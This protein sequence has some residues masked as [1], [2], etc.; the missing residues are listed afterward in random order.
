MVRNL[1]DNVLV[2]LETL[3]S[4]RGR[5]LEG[6]ARMALELWTEPLRIKREQSKRREE[7]AA[8]LNELL[9]GINET[10]SSRFLRP[11]HVAEAIGETH[12]E[13]VECWF[14]GEA[15]PSLSQLESVADYLGGTRDWL[16]HG[17]GSPFLV[18][19][20]R[21]P[22]NPTEAVW[23]LLQASGAGQKLS[24]LHLVRAA[25]AEGQLAIVKQYEDWR[26]E[27][28]ITPLHISEENGGTGQ[29]TLASF[30]V[31]LCLLYNTNLKAGCTVSSYVVGW[32]KYLSLINGQVHPLRLFTPQSKS[33]W[34]EDVW[35]ESLFRKH[36]RDV[37]WPGWKSLCEYISF[38]IEQSPYLRDERS[39]ILSGKHG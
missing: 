7:L 26:C 18:D 21:L 32:E 16:K 35:D 28:Y 19:Y 12:V 31:T 6:E 2:G 10:K 25:S 39:A 9:K 27:T 33:L 24:H 20:K 1:P 23:W 30:V 22:E 29:S 17:D 14:T 13:Q 8:R 34:W 3:A 36:E 11:S 37:Y 4:Q 15:E 38:L 5:S